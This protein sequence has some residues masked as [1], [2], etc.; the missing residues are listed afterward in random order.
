MDGPTILLY[1][2]YGYT[3][4]LIALEASERS[5]PVVLAGRDEAALATQAATLDCSWRAFGLDDPRAIDAEIRDVDAVL[6]CAGPFVDTYDPLVEACLRTGTHYVDI[7]GEVPVFQ[8]LRERD[9]RAVNAGVT[10]LPGAG[11][12]VVP[13]DCLAA[14]LAARLP[15]GNDLALGYDAGGSFSR[16]TL[17]TAVEQFAAGGLVRRDDRL[18]SVPTAWQTRQIDFGDGPRPA[19][20]VPLGDVVT[21]AH[22][23]GIPNVTVYVALPS[24]AIRLLRLGRSVESAVALSPVKRGL[25]WLLDHLVSGPDQRSRERTGA[26]IWGTVRSPD[27]EAVVSRLQTP[28]TYTLTARAAIE[29]ARRVAIDEAA[30]GYQTPASAFGADFVLSFE[31]VERTAL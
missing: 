6:N 20:T 11:F 12:D 26:T 5:I 24:T 9:Q 18:V 27:G 23:T 29:I 3:G 2:S 8:A 31:G 30:A 4:R 25:Q 21:A 28:N 19:T 22:S 14:H 10:L 1:G 7:T 16:G 13:S 17:K 15:D